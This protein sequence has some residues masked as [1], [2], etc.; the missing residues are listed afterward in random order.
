M[1][2]GP[3]LSLTELFEEGRNCNGI[4]ALITERILNPSVRLP[5]GIRV[6]TRVSMVPGLGQCSWMIVVDG[7]HRLAPPGTHGAQNAS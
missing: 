4:L 7:R 5:E 3:S 1:A 2:S 6:A